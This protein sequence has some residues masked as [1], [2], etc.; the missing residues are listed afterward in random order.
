LCAHD[1]VLE[2]ERK[3]LGLGFL[4]PDRLNDAGYQLGLRSDDFLGCGHG[5]VYCFACVCGEL[6]QTPSIHQCS[7]LAA[8]NGVPDMPRIL[9]DILFFADIRDGELVN[10]ATDVLNRSQDRSREFFRELSADTI[11]AINRGLAI[12]AEHRRTTTPRR[13][14]TP[15]RGRVV[16]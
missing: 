13:A 10:Y 9:D 2:S 8:D 7:Q 11:R 6:D 15:L 3:L 4:Q 1:K 5:F 14:T 12:E 16:A